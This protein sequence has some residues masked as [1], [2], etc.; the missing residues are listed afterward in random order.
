MK[1]NPND[2]QRLRARDARAMWVLRYLPLVLV[3]V[4]W[5]LV[6]F[7]YYNN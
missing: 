1:F 7:V 6:A 5:A 3:I 2:T 4:T